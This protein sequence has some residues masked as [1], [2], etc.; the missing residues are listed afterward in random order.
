MFS[1]FLTFFVLRFS[2]SQ[3]L[4]FRIIFVCL[5]LFQR[6]RFF[7]S[8][9]SSSPPPFLLFFFSRSLS[10]YGRSAFQVICVALSVDRGCLREPLQH[11]KV[12]WANHMGCEQM[13]L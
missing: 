4:F 3:C 11:V 10:L 12:Q 5:F 8:L 2:S 6:F 7:F 13:V 1:A 9:F